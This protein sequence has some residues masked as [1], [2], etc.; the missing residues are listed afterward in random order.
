MKALE[1]LSYPHSRVARVGGV[2]AT[3][4]ARLEISFCFLTGFELGTSK[5]TLLGHALSLREISSMQ[6]AMNFVPVMPALLKRRPKEAA[7]EVTADA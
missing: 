5:E 2:S 7:A 4:L 1:D 3:E 6:G